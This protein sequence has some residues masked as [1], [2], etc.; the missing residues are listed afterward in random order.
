MVTPLGRITSDGEGAGEC[1]SEGESEYGG[2]DKCEDEG[3]DKCEDEGEANR[4]DGDED[5]SLTF[6]DTGVGEA[7]T[8]AA[9]AIVAAEAAAQAVNTFR[10]HEDLCSDRG[11]RKAN[12]DTSS[13]GSTMKALKYPSSVSLPRRKFLGIWMGRSR[14]FRANTP[15]VL[16]LTM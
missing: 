2:E 1:V 14:S 15:L 10:N 9:Q 6:D 16:A 4:E 7:S 8:T 5:D 11:R 12:P 3:E 13:V